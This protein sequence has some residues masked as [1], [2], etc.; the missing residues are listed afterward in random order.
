[1]YIEHQA[2]KFP[3]HTPIVFPEY[4]FHLPASFYQQGSREDQPIT[5]SH[6]AFTHLLLWPWAPIW[7]E[8]V[9][10]AIFKHRYL[11]AGYYII[12]LFFL[13]LPHWGFTITSFQVKPVD[14]D[15]TEE[16]R[17]LPSFHV[18]YRSI[19]TIV[20]DVIKD[21]WFWLNLKALENW[22]RSQFSKD[23]FLTDKTI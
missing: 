5:G 12:S 23:Y 14:Q 3:F 13:C 6:L 18:C 11:R 17:Q 2:C 1:M 19:I 20:L 10:S 21:S 7:L 16:E 8:G 9:N 22:N 15:K 4:L